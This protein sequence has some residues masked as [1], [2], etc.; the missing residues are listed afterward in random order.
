MDHYSA[1]NQLSKSLSESASDLLDIKTTLLDK[2]RETEN[3][4]LQ[5]SRTQTDLQEGLMDSRTVP[6]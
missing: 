2:T 1:L 3:L 6:F 4:L 5:L